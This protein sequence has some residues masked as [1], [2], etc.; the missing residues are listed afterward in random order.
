MLSSYILIDTII[1]LVL[2][3][4]SLFASVRRRLAKRVVKTR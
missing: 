1:H 4:G 2:N 3:G